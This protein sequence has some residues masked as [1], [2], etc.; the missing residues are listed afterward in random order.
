[1]VV[2]SLASLFCRVIVTT[3]EDVKM[4]RCNSNNMPIASFFFF[5]FRWGLPLWPRVASH[6]GNPALTWA[7]GLQA[8]LTRVGSI[9]TFL[10]AALC[11]CA[12]GLHSSVLWGEGKGRWGGKAS[13]CVPSASARTCYRMPSYRLRSSLSQ[14]VCQITAW[15]AEKQTDRYN[16]CNLTVISASRSLAH[17]S[18]VCPMTGYWT[19]SY[20][21]VTILWESFSL[22]VA[23]SLAH[24]GRWHKR[25]GKLTVKETAVWGGQWFALIHFACPVGRFI[26]SSSLWPSNRWWVIN[27]TR[28]LHLIS[29]KHAVCWLTEISA[30]QAFPCKYN[31][32]FVV[33]V[34]GKR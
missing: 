27:L 21:L 34:A 1:M 7:L 16:L 9:P 32:L 25:T 20:E 22:P 19:Q 4:F 5:F 17:T 26:F 24:C 23:P 29:L 15:M 12:T 14:D 8:C 6:S 11:K 2:M 3:T 31:S 10:S 33:E 13:V 30:F 18:V 28:Q